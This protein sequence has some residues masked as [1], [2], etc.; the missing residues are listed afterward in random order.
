MNE[1]NNSEASN[2]INRNYIDYNY[3]YDGD[4]LV[5]IEGL[6]QITYD[7]QGRPLTYNG[8]NLS[9]DYRNLVSIG[10]NIF[11]YDE[12][13]RRISKNNINF[14]Y[15]SNNKLIKQSNGL[16]F[17][18]DNTGVAGFIYK[19]DKYIYRKNLLGDIT[20]IIDSNGNII[21]KYVY[22]A[23]GNH[24]VC[25]PNGSENASESFIGN[26]NPFRYRGYYYDEET[27]LFWCNSRYYNPE[28]GR[29]ISP[30]SIE[31]LDPSSINGLNLYAYCGNDPVNMYDPSGCFAISTFLIGMAVS[32]LIGWGLSEIFGAQ[33]VGGAS[34]II[35]GAGA[36]KTGV[37]L[38]FLGPWGIVA[39]AALML[40]GGA[41]IA[42]GVNEIVDGVTGTNYIQGWTGWSDDL[43]SGLYMGLNVA[44]TVGTIAGN[45]HLNRI[46]TNALNGLDDATYGPK[47]SQHI[48]K[49]SYYDSKLTQQ[50]II[51]GGQ[52]R[53][54][55]YGVP[56]Y[57]FRIKGTTVMGKS[58]NIHSG[59]WSLVYGDGI[60][61]H[62]LLS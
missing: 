5:S 1:T 31:Y 62:F 59:T 30:D 2:E 57:E 18:Y 32:S 44:S 35:N 40:V 51:K 54:A 6:L 58:G 61:W 11:T 41:T 10:D 47:A 13:G 24:K 17:F 23:W 15:D 55:K 8:M 14:T 22:D 60:I 27:G 50:E 46:R 36:I 25:N 56:G 39:G 49:R 53:R 42:F 38:C 29:W 26:L 45:M 3:V 12:L 19:E 7:N 16:E 21:V 20:D 34:S 48:G 28:W 4:K 52:I 9:W 33:V 43:Y 37:S